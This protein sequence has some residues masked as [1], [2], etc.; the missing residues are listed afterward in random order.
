MDLGFY[1]NDMAL[2]DPRGWGLGTPVTQISTDIILY[3][4]IEFWWKWVCHPFSPINGPKFEQECIPVGCVPPA[5]YRTGESLSG[6]CLS[7][8]GSLSR[9]VSVQ[10]GLCQ[11]IPFPVDRKTPVKLLPC[12]KLRLR[13]VNIYNQ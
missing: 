3:W 9:E 2:A 8:G 10:G 5:L 13:M 4:R 1:A 6:G 7:P 12:P 11:G